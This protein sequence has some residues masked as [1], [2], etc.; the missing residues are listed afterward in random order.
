M[1]LLGRPSYF[2]PYLGPN[3]RESSRL[4]AKPGK[5][6]KSA[7]P[8]PAEFMGKRQDKILRFGLGWFK[9]NSET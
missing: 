5:V 2:R 1:L 9:E 4:A 6:A 3:L 7:F 8:F